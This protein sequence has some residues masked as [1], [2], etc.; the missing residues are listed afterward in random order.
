MFPLQVPE[1]ILGTVGQVL[2]LQV[3]QEDLRGSHPAF[4][5]VSLAK[6][7]FIIAIG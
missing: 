7:R 1:H 3:S 2:L 6:M 5:H 4:T